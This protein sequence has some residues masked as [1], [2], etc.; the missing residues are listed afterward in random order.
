MP[1]ITI[2]PA[3]ASDLPTL[4]DFD[5]GFSTDYVWQMDSREG[6]GEI[7]VTFREVR[8]PRSMRVHF[9][10]SGD[11]LTE[12]FA[13]QI[14][15]LVGESGGQIQGYLNLAPGPVA[16]SRRAAKK[17]PLDRPSSSPLSP[18]RSRPVR[19]DGIVSP[20]VNRST[21]AVG[22]TWIGRNVA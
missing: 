14:C 17:P 15:F 2:R 20:A 21:V 19:G 6:E 11:W 12:S 5:H 16:E 9:P 8:L 22:S 3:T 10:R 13:R 1:T 7:A 4:A 18:E